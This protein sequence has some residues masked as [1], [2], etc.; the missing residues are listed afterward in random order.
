MR[1]YKADSRKAWVSFGTRSPRSQR[2]ICAVVFISRY[3]DTS[4]W[5]IP[6][7]T[8]HLRNRFLIGYAFD[9]CFWVTAG[10]NGR[11][12]NIPDLILAL[13]GEEN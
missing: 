1:L 11:Q 10:S 7:A 5:V 6:L 9:T 8:R 2:E 4:F 12:H 13:Q 3:F